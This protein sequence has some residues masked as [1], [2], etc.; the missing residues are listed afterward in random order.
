V[1]VK[2]FADMAALAARHALHVVHDVP[3][4][5]THL[6]EACWVLAFRRREIWTRDLIRPQKSDP[7]LFEEF[8][9]SDLPFRVWCGVLLAASE[10]A[11]CLRSWGL[12]RQSLH[13][14]SDLRT[15]ILS[16]IHRD[17]DEMSPQSAEIEALRRKLELWTDRV[18][19]DPDRCRSHSELFGL[20]LSGQ[21]QSA[22]QGRH[23]IQSERLRRVYRTVDEVRPSSTFLQRL[24]GAPTG[25][26]LTPS[27]DRL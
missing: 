19:T 12:L 10:K 23:E 26:V 20:I 18:L 13:W 22:F 6:A 9:V 5:V 24:S 25:S 3:S 2:D 8:F 7:V 4:R 14:H 11:R 21:P 27:R 15:Q 17:W 16:R 1:I